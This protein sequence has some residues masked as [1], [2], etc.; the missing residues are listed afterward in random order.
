[1][2]WLTNADIEARVQE[3][4]LLDLAD[5]DASGVADTDVMSA[6]RADAEGE[7]EAALASRYVVPF[8]AAE[9]VLVEMGAVI[10]IHRLYLRRG[11]DSPAH[12]KEAFEAAH[13]LL[14]KIVAGQAHLTSASPQSNWL[15]HS[16]EI[17]DRTFTRDSL[18]DF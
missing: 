14:S 8:T 5:D 16:A 6:V 2:S 11:A 18:E 17:E 9:P 7:V 3:A 1:M 4:V 15:K 13:A 10:A 12:V